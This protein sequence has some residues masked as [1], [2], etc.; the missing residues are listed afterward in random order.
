MGCPP[1]PTNIINGI[2]KAAK[3]LDSKAKSKEVVS[4][5]RFDEAMLS[6]TKIEPRFTSLD[7]I[8]EGK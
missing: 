1:R 5:K 3:M 6:T 8:P 7:N 2:L 4:T